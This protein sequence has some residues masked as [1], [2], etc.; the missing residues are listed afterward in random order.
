MADYIKDIRSQIGNYP[1]ILT[2]AGGILTN[3]KNEVLL[4][5]RSDF[6]VWG[7]PGGAMEFGETAMETCVREFKEEAGINVSI[8][9]LLGVSTNQIQEYPNGDKAQCVVINFIVKKDSKSNCVLSD[10][11]L[12]LKYFS[13]DNLPK[14][15]NDQHYK[16]IEN[17][18]YNRFPYYD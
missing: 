4:Q 13:L 15:I 5:K 16:I 8:Q 6:N 10:E 3:E 18:Y 2:F 17:Y 9:E 14:L 11:T 12:D 7:L 1:I